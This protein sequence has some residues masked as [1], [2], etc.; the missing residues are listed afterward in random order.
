MLNTTTGSV[1]ILINELRLTPDVQCEIGL[2]TGK[3]L[4]GVDPTDLVLFQN[5]SDIL[6]W[7]EGPDND[8][9]IDVGSIVYISRKKK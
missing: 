5:Q 6:H 7:K 3:T 8:V 4:Q 2:V 1:K 9:F